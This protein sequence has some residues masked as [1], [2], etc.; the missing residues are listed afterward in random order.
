MDQYKFNQ[1]ELEPF[2]QYL[3]PLE[4]DGFMTDEDKKC[5]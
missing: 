3:F 1:L 2:L 4:Q 5:I